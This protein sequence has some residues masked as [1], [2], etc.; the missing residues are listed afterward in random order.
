[1]GTSPA[2]AKL[3]GQCLASCVSGC[4]S[5]VEVSGDPTGEGE[6]L[7]IKSCSLECDGKASGNA[8]ETAEGAFK[9]ARVIESNDKIETIGVMQVGQQ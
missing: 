4:D 2:S 6:A 3:R 8:D 1:M 5:M 7:C 9:Y